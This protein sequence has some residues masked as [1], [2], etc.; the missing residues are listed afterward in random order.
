MDL[1]GLSDHVP[2]VATFRQDS[3]RPRVKRGWKIWIADTPEFKAPNSDILVLTAS[4]SDD[5]DN[6]RETLKQLCSQVLE[7]CSCRLARTSE[8]NHALSPQGSPG[9]QVLTRWRCSKATPEIL[10]TVSVMN[11]SVKEALVALARDL[12]E[13]HA[14]DP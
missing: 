8:E 5:I 12:A 7:A 2:V 11:F 10:Y 4:L 6:A 9:R 1:T 13:E 14:T 3:G